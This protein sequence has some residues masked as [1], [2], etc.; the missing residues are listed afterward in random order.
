MSQCSSAV[1]CTKAD[2]SATWLNS[3]SSDANGLQGDALVSSPSHSALPAAT[4]RKSLTFSTRYVTASFAGA[5]EYTQ[6]NRLERALMKRIA[7]KE[8][9]FTDT[10]ND[11][12]YTDWAQVT[13]FAERFSALG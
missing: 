9:G 11:H 2:I 7:K 13:N 12:E 3:S 1:P 8:G 10:S 6:Y 5:L 4:P